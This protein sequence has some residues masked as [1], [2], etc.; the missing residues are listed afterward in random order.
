[1][2]GII[3]DKHNIYS[4][5]YVPELWS[6]VETIDLKLVIPAHFSLDGYNKPITAVLI[7]LLVYLAQ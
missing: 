3:Y 6:F 5:G 1:M 7:G 4:R 2:N